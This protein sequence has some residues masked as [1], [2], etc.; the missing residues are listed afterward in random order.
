MSRRCTCTFHQGL[1]VLSILAHLSLFLLFLAA[2]SKAVRLD[3]STPSGLQAIHTPWPMILLAAPLRCLEILKHGW[4][5]KEHFLVKLHAPQQILRVRSALE[6]LLRRLRHQQQ[7]CEQCHCVRARA[8][9]QRN[10]TGLIQGFDSYHLNRNSSQEMW[11]LD[12]SCIHSTNWLK[13]NSAEKTNGSLS[14]GQEQ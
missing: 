10:A 3:F 5:L 1:H 7:H 8:A 13:E 4:C 11:R 14:F 12:A 9:R 6:L 2:T